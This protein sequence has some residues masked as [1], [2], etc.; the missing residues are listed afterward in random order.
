MALAE[1]VHALFQYNPKFGEVDTMPLE[2]TF[3]AVVRAAKV[4]SV[5]AIPIT[6][7][8]TIAVVIES[9]CFSVNCPSI[10]IRLYRKS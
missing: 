7:N 4:V 5:K 1:L 10:I 6:A 3:V 2:G 8:A 9:L